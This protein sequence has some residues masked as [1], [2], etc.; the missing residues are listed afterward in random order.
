MRAKVKNQRGKAPRSDSSPTAHRRPHRDVRG[1]G[2]PAP[3][4]SDRECRRQ[5]G[6]ATLARRSGD[7][8]RA[9]HAQSPR[10]VGRL[11]RRTRRGSGPLR[12]R[13]PAARPDHH[14]RA[15]DRRLL[16]GILQRDVVAA[17]P[18]CHRP[19]GVSSGVVGRVR[20]GQSALRRRDGEDRRASCGGLG[21]GLSASAGAPDAAREATRSEDRLLPAHPVPAHRAL[22]PAA[23]AEPDPARAAG[24][25]SG[26]I[27]AARR[28]PELRPTRPAAAAPGNPTGS[29]PPSRR[30][31]GAGPVVPHRDR[32]EGFSRAVGDHGGRGTRRGDPARPRGS[33]LHLPR[34]GPTRLHQGTAGTDP[35]VRRADRRGR[36]QPGERRSGPARDPVPGAGRP[37]PAAPRRHRP[38]GR[39]DQ[40][41]RR[42]DRAAADRLP[43][44]VISRARRWRRSIEP[45]TSWWS[46]R[47][48]TG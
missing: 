38:D 19:P 17:L 14:Q 48:E 25:G 15:G 1:G 40:R 21:P 22:Q 7:R 44:H 3:R 20:H 16:R 26:R 34:R 4:R 32:C 6:L 35:G 8:L 41:R 10:C 23:V 47:C 37:V 11:A 12:E 42:A 27:P 29:H 30:S 28:R 45:P 18:R 5:R 36:D 9:R 24:R 2:Q 31:P 33:E 46:R 43:A 39:S 13:R